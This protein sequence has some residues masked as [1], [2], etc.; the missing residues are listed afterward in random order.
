MRVFLLVFAALIV[1][2]GTGF[3]AW[4]GMRPKPAPVEA[5]VVEAPPKPTEVF[6]AASELTVGTIILPDQLERMPMEKAAITPE[7]VVAD[8]AGEQL[9]VGSVARQVLPK[10]VPIARS[11]TVQPGDRGFLAAV[12]PEGMR[13][14]SIPI[15]EVGGISGLA[16][17]GDHVDIILTYSVAS[18]T[19]DIKR[20]VHASETV[21][22][23]IRVLA[24]DQRLQRSGPDTAP[25]TAD[26][27]PVAT[28]ATLE[29]T[30]QQ[31]ETITLATTL[32]ELSMVLNS[33]HDGGGDTPQPQA[34]AA[35]ADQQLTPVSA[36]LR[37]T[38]G[39]LLAIRPRNLTLDSDVTSLLQQ[40]PDTKA[41]GSQVQVVRGHASKNVVL[42]GSADAAATKGAT[43]MVAA[44][45]P[46]SA[47][48]N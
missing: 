20:D 9:L 41:L 44:E 25:G 45:A 32:G 17:P 48:Q 35:K 29:V 43:G 40:K 14:I 28:S 18:G 23:N 37:D 7:M 30:P 15:T 8:D 19:N 31:A 5:A 10:G 24:M 12:L 22:T 39:R 27:P 21:A 47:P 4:Y 36:K 2:A 13:A 46:G 3:Y 42:G 38:G 16:M 1:A 33:V 26:G 6:A 34:E 11:G